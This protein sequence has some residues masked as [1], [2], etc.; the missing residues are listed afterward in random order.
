MLGVGD[1]F[2]LDWLF[3]DRYLSAIPR[4]VCS[5]LNLNRYRSMKRVLNNIITL[6]IVYCMCH[7]RHFKNIIRPV[8]VTK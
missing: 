4:T 2:G 5:S 8:G 3:G 1:K 6:I 7:R